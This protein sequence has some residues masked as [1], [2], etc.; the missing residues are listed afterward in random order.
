M[1][2]V[3]LATLASSANLRNRRDFTILPY[4]IR[5]CKSS[6]LIVRTNISVI[7]IESLDTRVVKDRKIK[8]LKDTN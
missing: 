6:E 7:A 3:I 2:P 1:Q 5:I 8:A 4:Y